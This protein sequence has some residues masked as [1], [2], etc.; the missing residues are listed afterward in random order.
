MSGL[1][2][3]SPPLGYSRQNGYAVKDAETFSAIKAAW[4]LMETGTKSL[5]D[6]AK[7][8]MTKVSARSAKA[9]R[10]QRSGLKP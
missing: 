3:G 2:N 5:R 7:Y 4:E 8:S 6:M 9:T 1:H 10:K